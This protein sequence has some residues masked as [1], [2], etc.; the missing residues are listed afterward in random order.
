MCRAVLSILNSAR[1]WAVVSSLLVAF[2]LSACGGGDS[3]ESGGEEGITAKEAVAAFEEAAGGHKF[4]KAISLTDGAVAYGPKS[5]PD[6]EDVEQLNEALGESSVLW[7]VLVFDGGDPPLDKEAVE[8]AAFA[9]DK[10]KDEG[11]GVY[12]G[13]NDIAYMANGNVVVTGP[14]LDGNVDDVTLEGWQ[15]VLDEL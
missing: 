15:A 11:E 3:S 9:S 10:L 14:V 6:P 12:L 5:S 13:D 4:E 2:A 7:Q 8:A 1:L